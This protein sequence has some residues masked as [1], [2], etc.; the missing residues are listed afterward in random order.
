MTAGAERV[1]AEGL[2][3]GWEGDLGRSQFL[4]RR[5][6]VLLNIVPRPFAGAHSRWWVPEHRD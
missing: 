2:A 4:R 6:P 3:E 5:I 1:E